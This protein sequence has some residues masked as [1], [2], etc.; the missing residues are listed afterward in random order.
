MSTLKEDVKKVEELL[1]SKSPL[2]FFTKQQEPEYEILK[3]A[4]E[5]SGRDLAMYQYVT[6]Q[7]QAIHNFNTLKLQ[8][9]VNGEE[10]DKKALEDID[11]K[12]AIF[13]ENLRRG[14]YF[15]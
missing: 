2:G 8:A 9:F 7:K 5:N 14:V 10:F 12:I 11:E 3:L 13:E 6:A 15:K 1:N 4:V